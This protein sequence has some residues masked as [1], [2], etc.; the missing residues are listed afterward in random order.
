LQKAK[1]VPGSYHES[2]EWEILKMNW[3][4]LYKRV[5]EADAV[6]GSPPTKEHIGQKGAIRDTASPAAAATATAARQKTSSKVSV[7]VSDLRESKT[8][9]VSAG[10]PATMT[11]VISNSDFE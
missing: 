3:E 9:T 2:G 4:L 10:A 5:V 11:S 6:P 1:N 7:I 8:A